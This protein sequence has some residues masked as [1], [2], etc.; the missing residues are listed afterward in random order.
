[1]SF[2][3]FC[4]PAFTRAPALI[5][6]LLL[7]L[8]VLF[9]VIVIPRWERLSCPLAQF[10]AEAEGRDAGPRF[11]FPSVPAFHQPV[12]SGCGDSSH[13]RFRLLV[14]FGFKFC[15]S[16]LFGLCCCC[17]VGLLSLSVSVSL[18]LSV[19]LSLSLSLSHAHA[20]THAR[21]HAHT[22]THI[23]TCFGSQF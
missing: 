21:T 8:A 11:A 10:I 6:Q 19:C 18:C 12:L 7:C 4:V 17:F 15:C 2:W 13:A 9:R 23:H 14:W 1:M 5:G 3:W 16:C 20:R 22:H